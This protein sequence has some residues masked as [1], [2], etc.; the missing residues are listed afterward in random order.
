MRK[1]LLVY[2]YQRNLRASFHAILII[3]FYKWLLKALFKM[4]LSHFA[5]IVMTMIDWRYNNSRYQ[6]MQIMIEMN[7]TAY[8]LNEWNFTLNQISPK[9]CYCFHSTKFLL[10]CKSHWFPSSTVIFIWDKLT[11]HIFSDVLCGQLQCEDSKTSPV[12]HYG[13]AYSKISLDNGKQCRCENMLL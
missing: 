9:L 13:W 1:L 6:L 8:G 10:F 12:V 7:L 2:Y 4:K 3:I 11:F 5:E